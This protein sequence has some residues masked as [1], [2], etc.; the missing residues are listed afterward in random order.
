MSVSTLSW[1]LQVELQHLLLSKIRAAIATHPQMADILQV[2]PGLY[3]EALASEVPHCIT[4]IHRSDVDV[5]T[6]FL[7]I[8]F[9]T[10]VGKQN[11]RRISKSAPAHI[12]ARYP[13]LQTIVR[14]D[15][16]GLTMGKFVNR[17]HHEH[18]TQRIADLSSVLTWIRDERGNLIRTSDSLSKPGGELRL[19][20][21]GGHESSNGGTSRNVSGQ[22]VEVA[23]RYSEILDVVR[24]VGVRWPLGGVPRDN[25]AS[26][27][28][29]S[30]MVPFPSLH[31][32]GFASYS[33]PNISAHVARLLGV[34]NK[35]T[36]VATTAT[37]VTAAAT[38]RQGAGFVGPRLP[39]ANR[40]MAVVAL[41]KR[42]LA[43]LL[44]KP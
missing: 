19:R 18:R 25:D 41:W 3:W 7:V 38:G 28:L 20:L 42:I 6:P 14:L 1:A 16:G 8:H 34:D 36:A 21:P 5:D 40:A 44:R 35:T 27:A 12:M 32:H 37:S 13:D 24:M 31:R 33:I 17:E 30:S 22:G 9:R 15:F 4:A 43:R 10:L 29:Q 26:T 11:K 2:S 23:I 39:V